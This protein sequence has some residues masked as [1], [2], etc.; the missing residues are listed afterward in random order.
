MRTVSIALLGLVL[1]FFFG[2]ALA[3]MAGMIS[4]TVF[5]STPSGL[6]LLDAEE[7]AG[8]LCA[9]VRRRNGHRVPPP[10]GGLAP[11]PFREE[12]T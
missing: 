5:S 11:V 3:A 10:Q 12:M 7:L 4:F 9:R 8:R 6:V 2:E 1:G